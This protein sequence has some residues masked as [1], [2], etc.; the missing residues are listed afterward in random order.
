MSENNRAKCE[1]IDNIV[2]PCK[3]LYEASEFGNPSGNRKGIY[4]WDFYKFTDNKNTQR[5]NTRRFFGVKSGGFVKT[6]LKFE[7]CPF[8]G[9]KI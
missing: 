1:L 2:E 4:C 7:Y 6:G 3:F 5:E 8:C 9:T